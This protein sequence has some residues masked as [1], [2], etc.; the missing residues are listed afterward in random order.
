MGLG[1]HPATVLALVSQVTIP[2]FSAELV[3][4][5]NG[6]LLAIRVDVPSDVG[7]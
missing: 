2:S 4:G 6:T 1:V 7:S 3:R 5:A